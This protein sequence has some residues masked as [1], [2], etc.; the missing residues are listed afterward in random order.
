MDVRDSFHQRRVTVESSRDVVER[1]KEVMKTRE[2]REAME[3]RV[4]WYRR[5]STG[6]RS[7]TH[8]STD[9]LAEAYRK[10]NAANRKDEESNRS[11]GN[12]STDE[13]DEAVQAEALQNLFDN[14][15]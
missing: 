7:V 13:E 11:D 3:G 12:N 6:K 1:I 8:H 10:Q 9:S 15:Q 14:E 2:G 4:K 5:H